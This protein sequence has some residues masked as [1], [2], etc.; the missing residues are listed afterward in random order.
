MPKQLDQLP[1]DP[2]SLAR[3]VQALEREVREMRAAR[4]MGTATVGR[5][6]IYSADGQ[7]L[8]A[9]LGPTDDGGGG[10]QTLGT[11][12]AGDVPLHASLALGQLRFQPVDDTVSSV[13]ARVSFDVSSEGSDLLLNSGSVLSSDWE[14]MVDMAS[15]RG[16]GP[17]KLLISGNRTTDDEAELGQCDTDVYGVLTAANIAYGQ[18][19][20]TGTTAN[21]PASVPVNGLGLLGSTFY[22][23]AAASTIAPG[24]VVTGVSTT[25]VTADGLTVWATRANLNATLVN[26]MV[27]GV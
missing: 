16:G 10:L 4:R 11:S 20:I 22:G 25:G 5:L 9:E 1:S 23:F 26:W 7:T 19:S 2:T 12:S 18:V 17:A 14:V 6:R 13:P 27:I 24:S 3:R 21:V 8:L 15:V